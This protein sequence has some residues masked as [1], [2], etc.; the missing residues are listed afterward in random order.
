MQRQEGNLKLK[1]KNC[2]DYHNCI[3]NVQKRM[4]LGMPVD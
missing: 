3:I 1:K 2:F 4:R